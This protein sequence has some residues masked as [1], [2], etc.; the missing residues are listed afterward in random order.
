MNQASVQYVL[1][2]TK[3]YLPDTE[4]KFSSINE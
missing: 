2:K 3:Y 4:P 1:Q